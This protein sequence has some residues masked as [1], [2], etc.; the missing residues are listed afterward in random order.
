LETYPPKE[1]LRRRILG[2][3]GVIPEALAGMIPA[4]AAARNPVLGG[5]KGGFIWLS[6]L[7][8]PI[9][10]HRQLEGMS[11]ARAVIFDRFDAL[12]GFAAVVEFPGMVLGQGVEVVFGRRGQG[13]VILAPSFWGMDP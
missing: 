9:P 7:F 11:P 4:G 12:R 8:P 3:I 13:S 1:W 2:G 5:V 10:Y 6:E